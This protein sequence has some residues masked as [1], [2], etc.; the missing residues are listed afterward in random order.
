MGKI[1]SI[2]SFGTV[3]GPGIRYVV[4]FQG[5]P[6]R[7]LYCHNPDTWSLDGGREVTAEEILAGYEKN[8]AFY[9]NGGIT[10]TGGE[11][12]MQLAFL[13][14]LFEECRE[15]K[16]HTCLDTSGITYT[17][18]KKMEYERLLRSVNFVLL[19]I[20]HGEEKGHKELTSLPGQNVWEFLGLLD[21]ME[22]PV[23]IRHVLVPG[24]T[25]KKRALYHL[26]ARL[27]DYKNI[28]ELEVLPYHRLGV[29]KYEQLSMDYPL[30]EV[31]E[32][33][34]EELLIARQIIQKGFLGKD[35]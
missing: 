26:G 8:K 5:C 2:E 35:L 24:I 20:K 4:F 7:C 16:I 17:S 18:G 21:E 34:K 32:P 28:K 1:H 19:D 12:L 30:K 31:R 23:R 25:M 13:T 10:A 14:Q 15:A 11:P 22:I 29:N 9:V 33:S 3:D 27:R 6:M